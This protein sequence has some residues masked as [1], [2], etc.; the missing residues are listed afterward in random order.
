MPR[1]PL[2][3]ARDFVGYGRRP[4]DF[5]WPD[6]SSVA[7]NIVINYEEGAEYNFLDGDLQQDA[8]GEYTSGIE[9]PFR[10]IQAEGSYEYGARVGIWRLARMFDEYAV[11]VTIGACAVA[12]ERNPEVCAW[13][14]E[15]QHDIIGHGY[16]WL[17]EYRLGR[18]EERE[19]LELAIASIQRST[20]HRI[21]GWYLRSF[22]S[23]NTRE[24]LVENGGFLYDSDSLNDEIPY[25]ADV[26]GTPFLV[27]P[28]TK[29]H[30]DVR[31]FLPP[32]PGN[33]M[34]FFENLRLALDCLVAEAE[35]GHGG[36]TMT[37][38]L[39][40]RWI[41]QP[42]R[43]PALR[44]FIEYV[45]AKEGACFMRRGDIAAFWLEHFPPGAGGSVLPG[46]GGA[47]PA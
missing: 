7:V 44:A 19:N 22:P 47:A 2:G 43:A 46:P 9:G 13:L 45:L 18:H 20:G 15:S 21:R 6:G 29:V 31:F 10:D 1:P 42:N 40:P 39:H 4:P 36:R 38:G 27:V 23:V 28:Y 24:L 8:W 26:K 25:Y 41:G 35:A 12:L 37:L 17:D 16:R 33:S 14:R 30:N 3:P 34:D 5:R 11:D 32:T